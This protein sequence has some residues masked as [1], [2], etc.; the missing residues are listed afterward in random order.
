MTDKT[1]PKTAETA[2]EAASIPVTEINL[3]AIDGAATYLIGANGE[4][5]SIT[6]DGQAPDVV[7][8]AHST[9]KN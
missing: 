5:L 9:A 3:G 4:I 2:D 8:P 6:K 1:E 7:P